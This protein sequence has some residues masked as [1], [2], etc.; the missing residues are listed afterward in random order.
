MR[1]RTGEASCSLVFV[2][3]TT[4]SLPSSHPKLTGKMKLL[5]IYN[6][7]GRFDV[8]AVADT[9]ST[10]P[11]QRHSETV[12]DNTQSEMHDNNKTRIR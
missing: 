2:S 3:G 4:Q 9:R 8:G 5:V 6:R 11:R 12:V 10:A 1:Y 7:I